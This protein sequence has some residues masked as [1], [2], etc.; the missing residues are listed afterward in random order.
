M[1]RR[2]VV[3]LALLPAVAVAHAWGVPLGL[4]AGT[5]QGT[6]SDRTVTLG[7]SAAIAA[8]D[9]WL[10][11]MFVVIFG[12]KLEREFASLDLDQLRARA[13]AHAHRR[14]GQMPHVEQGT[15]RLVPGRHER[16]GRL[17]GGGLDQVDHHRR[18]EHA[19]LAGAD[20]RGS[21]FFGDGDFDVTGKSGLDVFNGH[22]DSC[23]C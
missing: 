14:G 4:I 18:G 10:A 11:M 19:H 3:L 12:V 6:V 9:F 16:L 17:E 2:F 22:G 20:V 23:L 15:H 21:V 5:R 8:P 7:T 13:H 1:M